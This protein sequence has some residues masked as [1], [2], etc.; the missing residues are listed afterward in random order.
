MKYIGR[1]LGWILLAINL[2]MAVLLLLCAYS[3]YINPVSHPIG[4]CAGLA[5]PA[6]LIVNILFFIFWLIVYRKYALLSLLTFFCSF[7]AIRTYIPI[8]LFSGDSPENAI[9]FLSYNTMAFELG[10]PDRKDDPNNV[11]QYLKN[12]DADIIC[13]QEYILCSRLKKK[14]IDKVLKSYPYKHYY[15]I[16]DGYNGLGCYSR[17][18]ILSAKP[19][20]YA[21]K[22]NGSIAYEMNINGDTV[23][24]I[25]NH[26]ESNKLTEKDKAVYRDMIKDPDKHKVSAGSRLLIRKLAE[27]SAI[28]ASQV[29][30]IVNLVNVYQNKGRGVIV[31]GDFNDSPISY[32]HHKVENLLSDA[33][34]QSGNGFGVS[35]N[36][37]RFY[38]RI[39]HIFISRGFESYECMVDK[40][41]KSSDHYPI[42]CYIAKK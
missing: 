11:L 36:Q 26:L 33:F 34:V 27:A 8:N 1:F 30:S 40:S 14:D 9:K 18:P 39:D 37:N 19:L 17:F 12:S 15:E 2:C 7:G 41:I 38:F 4:S 10:K 31:C 16:A 24:V 25:N 5:F 28:R 6:F 32:A 42:W 29:D 35:Y 13:L 23:L 3:P 21:S 22:R 20:K